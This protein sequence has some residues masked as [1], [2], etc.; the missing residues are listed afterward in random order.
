MDPG[1]GKTYVV[2]LFLKYVEEVAADMFPKVVY[3]VPTKWLRKLAEGVAK[4]FE[5]KTMPTIVTPDHLMH[6][7][8]RKEAK[9]LFIVDETVST[10]KSSQLVFGK[11]SHEVKGLLACGYTESKAIFLNGFCYER[12]RAFIQANYEGVK[13]LNMGRNAD[14]A[15]HVKTVGQFQVRCRPKDADLQLL[16]Y[17]DIRKVTKSGTNVIVFGSVFDQAK[18]NFLKEV[19]IHQVYTDQEATDF[20]HNCFGLSG[21][22]VFADWEYSV[23]MDWR[24][25]SNA[26]VFAVYRQLPDVEEMMQCL[27]RGARDMSTNLGTVYVLKDQWSEPTV[28]DGLLLSEGYDWAEGAQILKALSAMNAMSAEDKAYGA[29]H[30]PKEWTTTLA[31]FFH[32]M[33]AQWCGRLK[34][35]MGGKA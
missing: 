26:R 5:L 35:I 28:K 18:K 22:V 15:K 27:G 16:L 11:Q 12:T 9:V 24:M 30:L 23:G 2:M 32:R 4:D 31:K 10:L 1:S 6:P 8:P 34:A 29:K 19:P 3:V 17:K 25:Q 7:N 13:I 33:D 21:A 20:A 14:F